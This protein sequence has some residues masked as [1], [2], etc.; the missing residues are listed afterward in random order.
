MCHD[1]NSRNW[2]L[3]YYPIRANQ[4]IDEPQPHA[5]KVINHES[6]FQII[7]IFKS[8]HEVFFIARTIRT[9]FHE[10]DEIK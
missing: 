2:F 6:H 5:W 9:T 3:A 4:P 8:N 10:N 1:Q 7:Y